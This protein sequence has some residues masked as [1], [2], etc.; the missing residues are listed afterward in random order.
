MYA[1]A[2]GYYSDYQIHFAFPADTTRE[3][4]DSVVAHMNRIDQQDFR[5]IEIP[6]GIEP[7]RVNLHKVTVTVTTDGPTY[8]WWPTSV[9]W[10][11]EDEPEAHVQQLAWGPGIQLHGVGTDK[12]KLSDLMKTWVE[13]ARAKLAEGEQ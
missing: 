6:V 4:A 7:R 5:V 10:D 1:V 11:F 8:D 3:Q 2:S 13:A 9:I 12:P